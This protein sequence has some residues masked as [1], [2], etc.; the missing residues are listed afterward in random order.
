[1]TV[2]GTG[3]ALSQLITPYRKYC[4]LRTFWMSES[5][6]E[7]PKADKTGPNSS[8]PIESFPSRSNA[9]NTFLNSFIWRK[10]D[11]L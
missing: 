4:E 1:M 5:E 2:V 8:V 10:H 11:R 9:L 7:Y 3:R 6:G